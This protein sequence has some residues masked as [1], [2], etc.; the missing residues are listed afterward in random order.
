[1]PVKLIKIGK[2]R[3]SQIKHQKIMWNPKHS[4]KIK[5]G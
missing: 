4:K 3:I 5:H 2:V 1:M